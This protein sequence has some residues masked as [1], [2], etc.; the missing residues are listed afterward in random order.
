ML[1]QLQTNHCK[2]NIIQTYAPTADKYDEDIE[3]EIEEF[4]NEI[5][6]IMQSLKSRD[7]TLVLGD[8][9][10]KIGRGDLI[11]VWENMDLVGE[12]KEATDC[13][14]F[15][16]RTILLYRTRSSNFQTVVW[17]PGNLRKTTNKI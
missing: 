13:C 15:A 17:S 3:E 4:Y 9:N 11:I 12:T 10:A 14:N 1:L 16:K 8:F 6:N 7:I 2:L 5:N